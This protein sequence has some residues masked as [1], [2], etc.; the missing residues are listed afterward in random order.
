AQGL[1]SFFNEEYAHYLFVADDLVLNPTINENNYA[2]IFNL[3]LEGCFIPRFVSL[4]ESRDWWGEGEAYRWNI[5][6]RGVEAVKQIP[7]YERA[8]QK[9]KKFG[10]EIKP[11]QFQQIWKTPESTNLWLENFFRII[12]YTLRYGHARLKGKTYSLSY[13]IVGSYS[14]IFVV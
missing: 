11:L 10:L 1:K 14:D 7:D 9:F 13:P 4:G 5:K 2:E 3:S 8:L 6:L 12:V